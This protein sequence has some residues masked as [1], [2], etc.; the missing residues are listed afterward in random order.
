[1]WLSRHIIAA[2]STRPFAEV[3]ETTGNTSMQS[4]NEYR[5]V[6]LAGPW[7]VA[8]APPASARTVLVDAGSGMACV[9]ALTEEKGIA[10]GELLLYSAGGAEIYLKNSG[11]VVINGRVFAAKGA[12]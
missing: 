2:E 4:A 1:M 7:G 11:E 6:P 8:Y 5:G 12:G 3:A 10:P 9:G